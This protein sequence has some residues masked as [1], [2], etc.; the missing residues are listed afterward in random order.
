MGFAGTARSGWR[1][2]GAAFSPQTERNAMP[3]SLDRRARKEP[4]SPNPHLEAFAR[5]AVYSMDHT[6]RSVLGIREFCDSDLCILPIAFRRAHSDMDLGKGMRI[7]KSDEMLE[8]HFCN[9]HLSSV[10]DCQ[11]PFGWAVRFRARM[12]TSS[13]PMSNETRSCK[14]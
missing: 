2:L 7:I 10:R 13:R 5:S 11:S 12:R 14:T 8:L 3:R 9:E 4:C 1:L 6:L